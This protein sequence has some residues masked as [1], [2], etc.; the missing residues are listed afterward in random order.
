MELRS[1]PEN[2]AQVFLN[3]LLHNLDKPLDLDPIWMHVNHENG[4]RKDLDGI[5]RYT[6]NQLLRIIQTAGS[7]AIKI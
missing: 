6:K 2:D 7:I 1:N 5:L 4:G 3:M